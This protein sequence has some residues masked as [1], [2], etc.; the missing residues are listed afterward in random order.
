IPVLFGMLTAAVTG[1][2]AVK[3]MLAVIKKAKYKWFSL[4]LVII[5][6]ASILTKVL[7]NA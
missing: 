6:T 2:I 3:L 5:A 1:Y 4:Y 7:F